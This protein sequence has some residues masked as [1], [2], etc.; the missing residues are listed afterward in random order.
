[1]PISNPF[2]SFCAPMRVVIENAY[3][4]ILNRKQ[5]R[6]HSTRLRSNGCYEHPVL[7][8]KSLRNGFQHFEC[9]ER[10]LRSAKVNTASKITLSDDSDVVRKRVHLP[11]RTKCRNAEH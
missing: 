4:R 11:A 3:A 7:H 5:S 10:V 2:T 8:C 9:S 6:A 1:M